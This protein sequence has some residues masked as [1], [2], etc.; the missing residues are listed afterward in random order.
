MARLYITPTNGTLQATNAYADWYIDYDQY[1]PIAVPWK[2]ATSGITYLNTSN[3]A[4]SSV[5]KLRYYDGAGR[6]TGANGSAA[7]GANWVELNPWPETLD[8]GK[9]YA[10]TARRPTGKAFSIVRMPLTI[11][12]AA[13]TTG[14][15]KGSVTVAAVTTH[16]DQVEVTAH[17]ADDPSKPEYVKG[18]NFIANPYMALH[19][20]ELSYTDAGTIEYANIPDVTFKEYDQVPIATTKLKPASGFLVQA[21]KTGTVTFGETNRWA[22]APSYRTKATDETPVQRAYIT[23]ANETNEDMMGLLIADKFTEAYETNADLEKLLSDGNTLR[24][25]MR[26]GDMNMAYVAINET[27][28]KE[29]IPVS[30]RIPADGEYTFSLHEASIAG[31]LEGVYLIDY[32]NGDKITNLIEQSYT[33]SSTAGT[34]N[35]RFA[36]N[37]KVGERQTPT[38]IDAINAGG[39]INSDKPFKFIY[40]DKVYI[41]INGIIYDTTGKRVK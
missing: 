27:L 2:V 8:P 11:P 24:T 22:S 30:V 10:M 34:I 31:E 14:G 37:A 35:G 41:W 29:W 28:A 17:G 23:L 25:Y 1:Y 21:P 3:A 26:Y 33:F 12:S 18:W 4:S 32:Q 20:G 19:Q 9:G 38:G 5:I 16:K 7:T 40:H 6:V 15:E 13:W 36:I 39:D